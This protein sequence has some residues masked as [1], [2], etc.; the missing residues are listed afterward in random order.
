ME[1]DD[2]CV[3]IK[4]PIACKRTVKQL[5]STSYFVG[6]TQEYQ[7]KLTF[8]TQKI[9][10]FRRY[11]E[12][13]QL[14]SSLSKDTL[15]ELPPFPKKKLLGKNR[16]F[17]ENRRILLEHWMRCSLDLPEI[18]RQVLQFL[19]VPEPLLSK[20]ALSRKHGCKLS[21]AQFC[22]AEFLRRLTQSEYTKSKALGRFDSEFFNNQNALSIEEYWY[23]LKKLIELCG[24]VAVGAK[25]L[26]VLHSLISRQKYRH[27]EKVLHE[28]FRLD[29]ACYKQMDLEL[30]LL[31]E[32]PGDSATAAYEILQLLKPHLED[33][34]MLHYIMSDNQEA[35]RLFT[36]WENQSVRWKSTSPECADEWQIMFPKDSGP[37][38]AKYKLEAQE[39]VMK[40]EMTIEAP[41]ERIRDLIR[42]PK[43]RKRWDYFLIDYCT[44]DDIS[45][46]F[47]VNAILPS[48]L[49]PIELRLTC[50]TVPDPTYTT[51]QYK[52]DPSSAERIECLYE[53]RSLGAKYRRRSST[54]EELSHD[55]L[56]SGVY[57]STSF[58]PEPESLT[59]LT[60]T[61][62]VSKELAKKS[63]GSEL[64]SESTCM[65]SGWLTLK[66]IAENNKVFAPRIYKS[67][68]NM[69][70]DALERK[71]SVS[72][73]SSNV[74]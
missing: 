24:L 25:A 31:S 69:M 9:V 21:N 58:S 20:V 4:I 11:C 61:N 46:C 29:T 62:I 70:L 65:K 18:P 68:S 27:F 45:D 16:Y 66:D 57:E 53:L 43:L 8:H 28:F 72:R 32:Y 10:V 60:Y 47:T 2:G 19:E 54:T 12:F 71:L 13:R 56:E 67:K 23:L 59:Q 36:N 39:I 40:F 3:S 42:V 38:A 33:N 74:Y 52:S 7:I 15:S 48:K 5:I 49:S 50:K 22:L 34:E 41:L 51:I 55:S 73:V 6:L 64:L 37:F 26:H 63:F 35:I 17:I 30:H 1:L 14:K 44:L